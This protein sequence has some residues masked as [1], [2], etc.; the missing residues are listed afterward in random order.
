VSKHDLSDQGCC[1]LRRTAKTNLA[2]TGE[3]DPSFGPFQDKFSFH[4]GKAAQDAEE[5]P[6]NR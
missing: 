4:G 5:E 2:L 3:S 6:A 1:D